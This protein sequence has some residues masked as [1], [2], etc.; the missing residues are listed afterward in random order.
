MSRS[1]VV[2]QARLALKMHRTDELSVALET[3][4][5]L[6]AGIGGPAPRPG[7]GEWTPGF[8]DLSAK[9]A[10]MDGVVVQH[11]DADACTAVPCL[12]VSASCA[13]EALLLLRRHKWGQWH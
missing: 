11:V 2:Y 6:S 1:S 13:K 3:I 9:S 5:R 4:C 8:A 12:M 7:P 10:G